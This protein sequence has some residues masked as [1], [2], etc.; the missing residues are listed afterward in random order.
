MAMTRRLWDWC[1][2]AIQVLGGLLL[3]WAA[4]LLLIASHR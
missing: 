3:L 4:P 1:W 2:T